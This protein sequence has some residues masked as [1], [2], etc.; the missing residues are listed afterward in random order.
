MRT[1]TGPA[2]WL[3]SQGEVVDVETCREE[4]APPPNFDWK[5]QKFQVL[6]KLALKCVETTERHCIV[7]LLALQFVH[8]EAKYS[9]LIA[10]QVCICCITSVPYYFGNPEQL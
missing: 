7:A 6:D 10:Q 4:T 1:T 3:L 2:L 8:G 9:T 5:Y